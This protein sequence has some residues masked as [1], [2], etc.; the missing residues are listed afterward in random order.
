MV[1]RTIQIFLLKQTDYFCL[2]E[3]FYGPQILL[4]RYLDVSLVFQIRPNF[5]QPQYDS[6]KVAMSH[7]FS[8]FLK[9]PNMSC[10][11]LNSKS[12]G[13]GKLLFKTIL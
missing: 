13:L 5:F 10:P 1:F 9:I 7:Y 8:I 12:K 3:S 11:Q 4:L 2:D 6:V